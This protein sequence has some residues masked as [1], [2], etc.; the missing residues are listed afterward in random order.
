MYRT[1]ILITY[2][3][4]YIYRSET[5]LP[6]AQIWSDVARVRECDA[7]SGPALGP[8]AIAGVAIA[9]I[10]SLALCC[11][12]LLFLLISCCSR[13]PANS[14][15]RWPDDS[16]H[17]S[18]HAGKYNPGGALLHGANPMGTSSQSP[19]SNG[20]KMLVHTRLTP[21]MPGKM[22]AALHRLADFAAAQVRLP[23]VPACITTLSCAS[24]C[25]SQCCPCPDVC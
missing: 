4:R 10:L 8:G 16:A 21:R 18:V 9:S 6:V 11:C 15:L 12:L 14:E 19:S 24:T 22:H 13:R 23:V 1:S 20:G 25:A 7:D 3:R 2:D 17:A 5:C